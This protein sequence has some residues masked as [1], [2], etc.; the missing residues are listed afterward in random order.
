MWRR[1]SSVRTWHW[2]TAW[3]CRW[4]FSQVST[5]AIRH[6]LVILLRSCWSYWLQEANRTRIQHCV[7]LLSLEIRAKYFSASQ[8]KL[9]PFTWRR[10][11]SSSFRFLLSRSSSNPIISSDS[12]TDLHEAPVLAFPDDRVTRWEVDEAAVFCLLFGC[13]GF[14]S[15]FC[16]SFCVSS[17]F[18]RV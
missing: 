2:Q 4:C 10:N 15:S 17:R 8:W 1:T 5:L 6:V 7:E 11:E 14:A 3:A 18:E 9:W 16:V 13:S 12:A